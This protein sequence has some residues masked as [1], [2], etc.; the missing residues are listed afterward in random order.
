MKRKL[1]ILA[2]VGLVAW[3]S[4][5]F[6]QTT[7]PAGEPPSAPTSANSGTVAAATPAPTVDATA[8]A[9]A[10]QATDA[11]TNAPAAADATATNAPATPAP[12]AN[13]PTGD[14]PATNAPAATP[15]TTP[16]PAT[17]DAASAPATSSGTAD[18]NAVAPGSVIPLIVMDDVPLTDAIKNLARQAG[19]NYILDP[20]V[21][22]GQV[23][24]DGRATPQPTVS[25][26]WEN[27]TAAQ[28]LTALLN[29]YNLQLTED[30]K[31]KIARVTVKDPAAPDPLVTKVIQL[32]FASPTNILV[33]IQNALTDKRSKVVGDVRTS[34]LVVLATEKEMVDVDLLVEKLDTQTRQVLIEAKLVETSVHPST[35]K[36][37]DWSGTLASQH[38]AFG[39]NLSIKPAQ[40]SVNPV[41]STLWPKALFDTAHGFNPATAFL[42]ADGVNAVFS[43]LN[44]Y[45]EA[46]VISSP[47]TVTLDNEPARIEVTRASPIINITAGTA[48]TTGGSQVNYT[49]LGIILNV[50]P[51]ISANNYVNLKVVPEVSRIFDTVHKSLGVQGVFEADEYD[52]RKME[53]RVLIPSGNTLVLG[54]LIQDDVREN[55]NKVPVLGDIPV[56]GYLFRSDNK[57]RQKSNLI[58]FLTP[59]II[60][61]SDFQPSKSDYLKTPAPTSDYIEGDWSSWD[62]GKPRDWSKPDPNPKDMDETA[63]FSDINVSSK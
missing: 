8:P 37:M 53:T 24:P 52:I 11:A 6:A 28:A 54:G 13:A 23:G 4:A 31:S 36:G 19:L 5:A 25:I 18:T 42:D 16:A 39:N 60:Q 61:D 29:T 55:N 20:K 33:S 7:S 30:P 1:C 59:T 15:A 51:R 48:N 63:K 50:V 21:S 56:L 35:S 3:G 57:S 34:Q 10:A 43:F 40:E 27:V 62:S 41:L 49:N 32:K 58:V 44:T 22:F 12:T 17:T 14:A 9:P 2:L 45:A 46:K 38:L 47:R 26:R